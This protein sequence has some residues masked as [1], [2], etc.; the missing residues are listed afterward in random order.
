MVVVYT[1]LAMG[2]LLMMVYCHFFFVGFCYLILS[3]ILFSY[4]C[5]I[6]SNGTIYLRCEDLRHLT[7]PKIKLNNKMKINMIIL[8]V[9]FHGSKR[10][11]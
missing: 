5:T 6:Y 7:P 3:T 2:Y 11:L 9:H 4:Q 8:F 10:V 1:Y